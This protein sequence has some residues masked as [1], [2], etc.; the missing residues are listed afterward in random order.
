MTAVDQQ[1]AGRA[2]KPAT[3]EASG[4]RAW[5]RKRAAWIAIG[6]VFLA[7]VT[8]LAVGQLSAPDDARPLSVRNPAPDGGM[9][10]AEILGRQGVRVTPTDTLPDTL[11]Q[12]SQK[13][14]PVLFLYDPRGFLDRSQLE[15]LRAAAEKIVVVGPRLR[16]L[17]GLDPAFGPG[18]VVPDAVTVLEPQCRE[19][20]PAAAGP[21]SAQGPVYTGPV[22]CYSIRPGAAGLYATSTD[23]SIVVLGSSG[24]VDNGYLAL[25]GN[26]ALALRTLGSG[27]ELVWYLPGPS[28]MS[29]DRS[30]PTLSELAPPWL[31][32]LGP[33]LGVVAVLAILWRGRRLGPLVFE[34][35]PVVVKAAE[36]AEGRARL[37]QDSRA[38]DRAADN[39]RAGLLSRLAKHFSLGPAAT[40]GSVVD[41]VAVAVG[42]PAP[43]LRS[44]L[45]D[46]RPQTEGQ[47]VQWAQQ[48][49]HIEQEA[50]AR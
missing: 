13:E 12:L 4:F 40:A 45:V 11:A 19:D 24:L 5:A 16:T 20:D 29:T 35:L 41:A 38:L 17:A 31:A 37:Y 1:Q 8:Y 32:F 47:L 14:D 15:E 36:T 2:Q 10:V 3:S 21:V 9:A 22:V 27:P 43:E 33:W 44:I 46:F 30:A 28:D 49:E 25:E 18:G 34:P 26:A 39:L 50:T 23:G 48:I 42:R 7:L 6:L